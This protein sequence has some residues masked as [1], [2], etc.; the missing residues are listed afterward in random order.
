MVLPDK[1][2]KPVIK[3]LINITVAN[4][5]TMTSRNIFVSGAQGLVMD[6]QPVE[7]VERK[8][9]GHPDSMADGL[10]EAVSQALCK[11]YME[12]YDTFMHHN[13]DQ[14]EI[15]GG[16]SNPVF[17]GG[18][19]LQPIYILLS[20]RATTEVGD[21]VL[22]VH[23]TAIRAAKD[24]LK[25]NLRNIDLETD[26]VVESKIGQGSVDLRDVFGRKGMPAANDTSFGCGFAPF[27][28]VEQIV[29]G[30]E[31]SLNGMSFKSKSPAVGEDIKVMGMRNGDDIDVTIAAAIVSGKTDSLDHYK[32]I[33]G[34]VKEEATK[35]AGTIT[36]RNVNVF[37]NTAD[38]YEE[39]SL[40]LTV[41][42]TSAEAGDDGS[43]GR[44]NRCNGLITPYR[45]MS[46]E[47]TSGKNPIN[48]V[49]KMYNL[50]SCKMANAIVE[51]AP[52]VQEAY[53]RIVSQIG[54][55]IDKPHMCNVEIHMEDGKKLS[56]S[57]TKIEQVTDYWLENITQIT[58]LVYKGKLD[59]F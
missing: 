14:V 51:E 54:H 25:A 28:E 56:D 47:A 39:E 22:G 8:G 58:D 44:G 31:K 53:V 43:T 10:S 13:T 52:G 34:E 21:D 23:T 42:G 3:T 24:Y 4:I 16:Q 12:K 59:T 46:M 2:L 18:E 35:I 7:M 57:K 9:I 50:L 48:H 30:I 1:D 36:S 6:K 45:P 41:T 17:G 40:F 15:V 19:M 32:S 27:S 49:G 26:V 38:K 37:V 29:Y 55:P 20:G 5:A 33:I 11:L